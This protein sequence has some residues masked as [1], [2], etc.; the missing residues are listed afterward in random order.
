MRKIDEFQC[1][2]FVATFGPHCI[3]VSSVSN[4][5]VIERMIKVKHSLFNYYC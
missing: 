4:K 3:L 1:N 2:D 5:F